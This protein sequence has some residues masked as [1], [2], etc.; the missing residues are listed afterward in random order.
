MLGAYLSFQFGR[1]AHTR[2][3]LVPN[4]LPSIV[5]GL[6]SAMG[7]AW[8]VIVAVEMLSGGAGIGFFVWDQYNAGSLASV[9]AAILLIGSVGV[10]L[11]ATFQR[12]NRRVTLEV[13]R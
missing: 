3:V 10:A 9:T 8:M 6:R 12:L 11:D 4:A 5:T 13:T 1:W 2:H 7:I